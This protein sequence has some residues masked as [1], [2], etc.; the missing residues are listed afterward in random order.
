MRAASVK[1]ITASMN[2]GMAHKISERTT[3]RVLKE[4]GFGSFKAVRKPFV[5]PKQAK[6]RLEW[7]KA[8]KNWTE[9][10]WLNVIWSDETSIEVGKGRSKRV[11]G[12]STEKYHRDCVQGTVKSGRINRMYWG[13]F[14]G[15]IPGP[16]FPAEGRL[17]STAF[18]SHD[19]WRRRLRRRSTF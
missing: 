5:T 2:E 16:L 14:S 9:Q 8:Y 17:D 18:T 3:R 13:C 7:A 19:Q 12:L 1:V 10:E 15:A 11:H 4:L 6:R